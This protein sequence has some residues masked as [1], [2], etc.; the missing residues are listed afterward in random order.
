MT[1]WIAAAAL[2]GL[3]C[4][5][6]LTALGRA[7]APAAGHDR[8]FYRA[9]IAEIDRQSGLGLIGEREAEA[10]RAEAARRLLAAAGADGAP[11]AD[12][13]LRN[14]AALAILLAV[15]AVAL[16]L[17][18]ARGAPELPSF[19]LASREQPKPAD[20]RQ[21]DVAAAV[22]R[23]ETHLAANPEDGRG[24]EVVAPVYLRLGRHAEAVRAY[25]AALRLLGAT[26]DRQASLGEAIALQAGGVV[27]AEARAAFE[28]AAGLDPRHAK[29]RF[30]L[31][32]AAQQDGDRPRAAALLTDLMKDLPEGELKAEIG[33]QLAAL[34]AP[35]GG[36]AV[37]AL[38]PEAQQAAIRGMVEGLAE[39]LA[40]SGG[41]AEDWARL[42]RALTVLKETE[43]AQTI[44][45]EA[46]QKF[47]GRPDE[48][49]RIEDA[50]ATP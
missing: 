28:A 32:L 16:P 30:F 40:A 24:H 11:A 46:R 27:T 20:P 47:A 25:A 48:L 10:A 12:G 43:R 2:L 39:R 44:L 18:L 19:P 22:Q 5:G 37:A 33:R 7:A 17:Y 21:V 41:S 8:D 50:G 4:L 42:I 13:R 6:L 31:A 38:A 29:A 36:E 49:K 45:A 23:I 34:G 9:Q 15:P 1:F 3:T 14:A 26:A 35:Q